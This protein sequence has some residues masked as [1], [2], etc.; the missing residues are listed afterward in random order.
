VK[1]LHTCH[2]HT[3]ITV[4]IQKIIFDTIFCF[5][6]RF[7]L[8]LFQTFAVPLVKPMKQRSMTVSRDTLNWFWFRIWITWFHWNWFRFRQVPVN[9]EPFSENDENLLVFWTRLGLIVIKSVAFVCIFIH[10]SC[11]II[12][13]NCYSYAAVSHNSTLRL[14][15]HLL[16]TKCDV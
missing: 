4:V 6:C 8:S 13:V 1:V 15:C 11:Y 7:L 5:L 14:C 10:S 3:N 16:P 2:I 9:R 12:S